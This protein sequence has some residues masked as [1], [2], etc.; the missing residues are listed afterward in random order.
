M[1]KKKRKKLVKEKN[2]PIDRYILGAHLQA[3]SN[4]CTFSEKSIHPF[5]R[6]CADK[7]MYTGGGQT[8][9]QTDGQ[10]DRLTDGRTYSQTDRIKPIYSTKLRLR[11]YNKHLFL[12]GHSL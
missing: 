4:Q 5:L 11:G 12:L 2:Y 8:D 1:N 9:R 10:T 7:I 6:T 3:V